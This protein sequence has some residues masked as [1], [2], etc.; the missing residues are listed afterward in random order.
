MI[1]ADWEFSKFVSVLVD[2]TEIGMDCYTAEKG[3]TVITLK[4]GYVNTLSP[5]NH[6]VGIRFTDGLAQTTLTLKEKENPAD[7]PENSGT[8]ENGS[9]AAEENGQPENISN[10]Q[11][12]PAQSLSQNLLPGQKIIDQSP[13][14]GDSAPIGWLLALLTVSALGMTVGRRWI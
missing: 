14:T 5:G 7:P 13:H 8:V 10:S 6:N 9:D 12:E 3:S 4:A 11:E 2:G 1:R